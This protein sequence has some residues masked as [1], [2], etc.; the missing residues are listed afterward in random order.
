MIEQILQHL[1]EPDT[2]DGHEMA[3]YYDAFKMYTKDRIVFNEK[4]REFTRAHAVPKW[5]I[6]LNVLLHIFKLN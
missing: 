3:E 6:Q 1:S 5:T 2:P 4:A